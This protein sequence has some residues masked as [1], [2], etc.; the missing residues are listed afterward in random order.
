MIADEE[1]IGM[2][3]DGRFDGLVRRLQA[4]IPS[5]RQLAEDAALEAVAR[6]LAHIERAPVTQVAAFLHRVAHNYMLKE[7]KRGLAQEQSLDDTRRT[8]V[9]AERSWSKS[10]L[11]F[12][13]LRE[14][15]PLKSASATPLCETQPSRIRDSRR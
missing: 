9:R 12:T 7:L 13:I 6:L 1:V 3:R 14:A 4:R 8:A 10:A 5:H 15:P 2:L 11:S